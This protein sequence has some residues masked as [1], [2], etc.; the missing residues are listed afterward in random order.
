[1]E[2]IEVKKMCQDHMHRYVCVWMEDGSMHDG[3]IENM[4]EEYLSLAI[5]VG[6]EYMNEMFA[7]MQTSMYAHQGVSCGC[8]PPPC[9]DTRAFMPFGGY[10]GYGGYPYHGGGY[11]PGRRRFR[12][13][14]LPLVGITALTLLPLL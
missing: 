12:R 2:K 10:G 7:S 6:S 3:I 8:P 5:P 1:M 11:Y 14:L 4:D 13:L 9:G